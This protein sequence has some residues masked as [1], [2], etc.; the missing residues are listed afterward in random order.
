M[1]SYL[2][3]DENFL[4]YRNELSTEFNILNSI[5]RYLENIRYQKNVKNSYTVVWYY[6]SFFVI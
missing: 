2:L 1:D 6:L 3:G 5:G 4:R